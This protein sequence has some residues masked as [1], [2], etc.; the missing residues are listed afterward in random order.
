MGFAFVIGAFAG[1]AVSA[2]HA[3]QPLHGWRCMGTAAA[4]SSTGSMEQDRVQRRGAWAPPIPAYASP[5]PGARQVGTAAGVILARV[6]PPQ[7]GRQLVLRS[8]GTQVWVEAARLVPWPAPCR[9][10][11]LDNG[12]YGFTR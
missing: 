10:A 4:F 7:G 11:L 12:R 2:A 9:P 5:S 6:A 3:A 8:N 1:L